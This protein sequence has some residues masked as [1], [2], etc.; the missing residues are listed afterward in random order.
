MATH[1][2]L[3]L[4]IL[5]S[6][7]FFAIFLLACK[8]VYERIELLHK[9]LHEQEQTRELLEHLLGHTHHLVTFTLD[10]QGR[11]ICASRHLEQMIGDW[12][13][14]PGFHL[15][16]GDRL[17]DLACHPLP[18]HVP[19]E[20]F[21]RPRF[22]QA[23]ARALKGERVVLQETREQLHYEQHIY[24]FRDHKGVIQG[25]TALIVDRTEL[26]MSQ[27]EVRS[28]RSSFEQ[29]FRASGEGFVLTDLQGVILTA[30]RFFCQLVEVG[31][32]S[33]LRGSAFQQYALGKW[34]SDFPKQAEVLR[35]QGHTQ[36]FELELQSMNGNKCIVEVCLNTYMLGD[37]PKGYWI[38]VRDISAQ[39]K[40]NR[41]LTMHRN[42]L[43]RMVSLRTIKVEHQKYRL[44]EQALK[45]Q[46]AHQKIQEANQA[47]EIKNQ[48]IAQQH[49]QMQ[50]SLCQLEEG[51]E[52]LKQMQT[53]LVN[54]EKMA[55]IG[56]LT[57]GIAHEINNPVNFIANSVLPLKDDIID[58][59]ILLRKVLDKAHTAGCLLKDDRDQT[60]I[61]ELFEEIE[62]LVENIEEGARRTTTIV[63]D[64]K[65][66]SRQQG[67]G[68]APADLEKTLNV[69]LSML[70]HHT[71]NRVQVERDFAGIPPVDCNSSRISQ[72]FMNLLANALQAIEGEGLLQL[73]TYVQ[74]EQAYIEVQD[75]GCGMDE[76]TQQKIFQPF[77]TTKKAGEGTGLGLAICQDIVQEHGGSL[78]VRSQP[79][80]GTTFI[81]ALPL[82]SPNVMA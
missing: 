78:S 17:N 21:D 24:P 66:F 67:D 58:V 10:T 23:M 11:V 46:L 61:R 80:R 54:Q 65:Y 53:Q 8:L 4:Y 12:L 50:E 13:Q 68:Y 51:H 25:I 64:L 37:T 43:E 9:R 57:A 44:E 72:V 19:A 48:E 55:T 41:E 45:L 33:M 31:D 73:R 75:S 70:S 34:L 35:A 60:E 77:F 71:R 5:L 6:G 20:L 36:P 28:M 7:L 42:H 62:L 16:K 81:L 30:N 1:Y 47:L 32:P 82:C 76:E 38:I 15:K 14:I 18:E 69:T 22:E 29:L 63:S 49:L 40:M 27:K 2:H 74:G 3:T 56:Q 39:R 59:R 79:G 52:Q 26:A